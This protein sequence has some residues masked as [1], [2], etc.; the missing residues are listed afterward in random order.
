MFAGFRFLR[1]CVGIRLLTNSI[2]DQRSAM[3]AENL[4]SGF[5]YEQCSR[6]GALVFMR[7]ILKGSVSQAQSAVTKVW[8]GCYFLVG[9]ESF[10][11]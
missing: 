5:W 2:P 6:L 1:P 11:R 10:D 9:F 8:N 7:V 3:N 4:T